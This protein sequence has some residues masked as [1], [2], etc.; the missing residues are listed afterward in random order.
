MRLDVMIGERMDGWY[1]YAME[2]KLKRTCEFGA[3]RF[4]FVPLVSA[5]AEYDHTESGG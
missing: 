3:F 1:V 4:E 5:V 2:M